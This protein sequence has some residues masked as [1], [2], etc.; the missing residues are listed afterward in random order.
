M[1]TKC[2]YQFETQDSPPLRITPRGMNEE[3]IPSFYYSSTTFIKLEEE[4][5]EKIS[6]LRNQI[7]FLNLSEGIAELL[8]KDEI[9]IRDAKFINFRAGDEIF[10]FNRVEVVQFSVD[11]IIR[12]RLTKLRFEYGQ[13]T[14]LCISL[15]LSI[16]HFQNYRDGR[17]DK[18]TKVLADKVNNYIHNQRYKGKRVFVY[19]SYDERERL[20][21]PERILELARRET[22]TRTEINANIFPSSFD[23]SVL[24]KCCI[25][26]TRNLEVG[27]ELNSTRSRSINNNT[28]QKNGITTKPNEEPIPCFFSMPQEMNFDFESDDS[29]DFE[30]IRND[31]DLAHELSLRISTFLANEALIET[32]PGSGS[33]EGARVTANDWNQLSIG[34][35]MGANVEF[36]STISEKSDPNFYARYTIIQI[37]KNVSYFLVNLRNN[38]PTPRIKE[39]VETHEIEQALKNNC[40]SIRHAIMFNSN[41]SKEMKMSYYEVIPIR[42][43][44]IIEFPVDEEMRNHLSD[45]DFENDATWDYCKSLGLNICKSFRWNALYQYQQGGLRQINTRIAEEL[46]KDLYEPNSIRKIFDMERIFQL[47]TKQIPSHRKDGNTSS[48]LPIYKRKFI[49]VDESNADYCDFGVERKK[50][51]TEDDLTQNDRGQGSIHPSSINTHNFEAHSFPQA[52][53]PSSTTPIFQSPNS[54]AWHRTK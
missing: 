19:G 15:D 27:L 32:P 21:D 35:I 45:F 26:E 29:N 2:I 42:Q 14:N 48:N 25:S 50:R 52:M 41:Y 39:L 11:K 10:D 6:H 13:L 3:Y 16:H 40:I 4:T 44:N 9:S 37:N 12:E 22:L 23:P 8:K 1:T 28:Y 18:I 46:N 5:K 53:S 24:K 17:H 7:P 47:A 51:R 49:F 31:S 33:V 36:P 20:F 34:K 54:H 43:N 30:S 38:P